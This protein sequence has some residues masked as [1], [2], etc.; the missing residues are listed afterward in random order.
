MQLS[1]VGIVRP[2]GERRQGEIKTN[3]FQSVH[4]STT[5][6]YSD[7]FAKASREIKINYYAKST[8]G[9]VGPSGV[10]MFYVHCA[11]V[12]ISMKATEDTETET[13]F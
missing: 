2:I 10:S 13:K 8:V 6:D 11:R 3:Y 7:H 5:H 12:K 4:C 9:L 1:N